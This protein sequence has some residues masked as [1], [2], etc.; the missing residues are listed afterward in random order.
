[1]YSYDAKAIDGF[2]TEI[3]PN[4]MP[5]HNPPGDSSPSLNSGGVT[6]ATVFVDGTSLPSDGLTRGVDAVSFVFM[7][8]QVMNE[9]T[10]ETLVGAAT[11]WVL[12]F[13]T[14]SF[15]VYEEESGS[16]ISYCSVHRNVGRSARST[17]S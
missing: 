16:A 5:L 1:M 9:Y 2:A 11:E 12:T 14:K 4:L 3:A 13:P 15:Y 8:D 17:G 7:H 10:T 6:D